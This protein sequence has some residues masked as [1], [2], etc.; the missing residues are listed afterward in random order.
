MYFND[1]KALIIQEDGCVQLEVNHPD[2]EQMRKE[3]ICFADLMKTP[4]QFHTFHITNTSLWNAAAMG[5]KAEEI[6]QFLTT[7]CK[8]KVPLSVIQQVQK[9]MHRYGTLQI[10]KENESL[11]INADTSLEQDWVQDKEIRSLLEE[12]IKEGKWKLKKQNRGILKK[13]M[14]SKGYPVIDKA[15]YDD[16]EQ[17]PIS[18]RDV[19]NSGEMF[20]IR[21]YQKEAVEAF[22][23]SKNIFSGSGVV[24]LPCGAGKTM[25]GIYAMAK[26]QCEVLILTSNKTSVKQWKREIADK[27]NISTSAIGEYTGDNKQIKP[28]TI[29][30]YQ[31]LTYR[32]DKQHD[33]KHMKLFS[34]RKWGLIIYDEVHLLPAPVFRATADLQATRRLGLTATL[35]REDGRETDVFSLV[36][37]KCYELH[38]KELEAKGWIAKVQC[39]EV[40]IDLSEADQKLYWESA[41]KYKHRIAGEN[42]NKLQYIQ[43]ILH[44]HAHQKILI[45]GQYITQ[46]EHIADVL[47]APVIHGK[48]NNETREAYYNAFKQGKL[49]ILIVSKVANFAVDLPN[50]T[51]AIQVSGSFGSRQ[52]EA[53][54]LGR[55]LRPKKGDNEAHFYSL[56]SK[57]TVEQENSMHRQL[58]LV[59][60]G[61]TYDIKEV[62]GDEKDGMYLV[63]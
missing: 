23:N 61:Y 49:N 28:I 11:Y 13:V 44:H 63:Q 39:H 24:H 7:H 52:E 1:E 30:T 2:Y 22:L 51:V 45:I 36:G 19:T 26:L 5:K 6:K 37:H 57:D 3:L 12:E 9:M 53:Q 47:K 60:Q 32:R 54:R 56:V 20:H 46:L 21:D 4:E 40:R 48:S 58:F 42:S 50:A 25:V 59:E 34:S 41:A 16:S 35:I 43:R 14:T 27:C 18:L 10:N 38:W 8:M 15:G 31:L 17:L 29:S 33:F 55:V 62:S